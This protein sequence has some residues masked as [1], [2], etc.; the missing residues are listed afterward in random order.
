MVI[1]LS[2]FVISG[3]ERFLPVEKK[4][5][6][7]SKDWDGS[8]W[9]EIKARPDILLYIPENIDTSTKVSTGTAELFGSEVHK[10][11]KHDVVEAGKGLHDL[12]ASVELLKIATDSN[13]INCPFSNDEVETNNINANTDG[14]A[15]SDA[16]SGSEEDLCPVSEKSEAAEAM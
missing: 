1:K 11:P 15:G 16:K 2:F 5:I 6:R 4:N 3:E 12:A 14:N 8:S 9:V 10:T 13:S 7:A